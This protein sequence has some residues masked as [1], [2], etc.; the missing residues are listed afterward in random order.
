[1][2]FLD[3]DGVK[4]CA[5]LHSQVDFVQDSRLESK[6]ASR[7]ATKNQNDRATTTVVGELDKSIRQLETTLLV[8][9]DQHRAV[10]DHVPLD[11][12]D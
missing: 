1:M 4:I 5:I 11:E 12:P 3:I 8:V 9:C 2:R 7:E 10:F 6:R